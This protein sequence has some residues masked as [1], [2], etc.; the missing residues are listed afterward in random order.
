MAHQW[1]DAAERSLLAGQFNRAARNAETVFRTEG[2]AES[3]ELKIRAAYVLLQALF[4]LNRF[5]PPLPPGS[6]QHLSSADLANAP[7]IHDSMTLAD[8]SSLAA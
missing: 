1:I 5:H 3:T 4:E 2:A 8:D 7:L 6:R